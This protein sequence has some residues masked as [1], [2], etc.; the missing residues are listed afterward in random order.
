MNTDNRYSEYIYYVKTSEGSTI[1]TLIDTFCKQLCKIELNLSKT[2][3]VSQMMNGK[4]KNNMLY[5]LE[6]L[7]DNFDEYYCEQEHICV[8]LNAHHTQDQTY[9]VKKK[10]TIIMYITK[11]QP[12]LFYIEVI[13][14]MNGEQRKKKGFV[15]IQK[16][17]Y[18]EIPLPDHYNDPILIESTDYH[19]MCKD[20]SRT[21]SKKI[22]MD[23]GYG[24]VRFRGESREITG[25]DFIFGNQ[26]SDEVL[27]TQTYECATLS[28]IVKAS[29]MSK[30]K[31]KIFAGFYENIHRPLKLAFRAGSLGKF[32]IYIKCEELM[33]YELESV[34]DESDDSDDDYS[35][36]E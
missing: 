31:I 12:D 14:Q 22:I 24:W 36:D 34:S 19:R 25:C 5:D 15:T 21:H 29:S 13:P 26:T 30:I 33:K 11:S 6:L 3:I 16:I 1:K 8:G 10:N 20:I 32:D 2:G 27:F 9:S 7:R 18:K 23:V 35:D 4:E 28:S 17:Q